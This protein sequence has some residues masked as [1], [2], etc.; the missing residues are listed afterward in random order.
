MIQFNYLPAF[1]LCLL[2]FTFAPSQK[3][4]ATHL[5]GG[6]LSYE[7]LGN[8]QYR[9]TLK[10]YR[11]CNGINAGSYEVMYMSA[12]CGSGAQYMTKVSSQEITPVCAGFTGTACNGGGGTYGIEEHIYQTTM[13]IPLTC[14]NIEL[15][16]RRCCRNGAITTLSSPLSERMYIETLLTDAAV[17]NNSPTFLNSPVSFICAGQPTDYNHGAS[18]P[19]GDDLQFSLTDCF[20]NDNDAVNYSAGFSATYPLSSAN[21]ITIDQET[22]ALSFTPST[23]GQVGVL[24]VLVEEFRNGVKISEISRDIQ[25]TVLTCT[26]DSPVMTGI[27]GSSNFSSTV[28]VGNTVSFFT[29]ASDPNAGD[30]VEMNWNQG[31]ASASF[32]VN[33]AGVYPVGTFNWTPTANN[34]GV[35]S[36]N[37]IVSDDNCPIIGLNT[38]TFDVTVILDDNL[39]NNSGSFTDPAIWSNNTVPT[40]DENIDISHDVNLSADF[41]VDVGSEFKIEPGATLTVEPGNTLT[42][43]GEFNNYGSIEGDVVIEG[44]NS[45]FVRLGECNNI[46]ITNSTNVLEADGCTIKGVLKLTDGTFSTNNQDVVMESDANGDAIVH[47]NGGTTLGDFIIRKYIQNTV[48]HHFL[49]SPVS[50]ASINELSDDIVINLNVAHPSLYYYDETIQSDHSSDGWKAPT[51]LSH[52]MT[53]G[54][55]VTAYFDATAGVTVDITGDFNAGT[56]CVPLNSTPP[57]IPYVGNCPP[58][59]WNLV[60]NPY[61]SPI[62]FDELMALSST[63]SDVENALYVWDPNTNTYLSYINGVSSPASFG[64]IIP[65]MQA[66][67]VRTSANT[68]LCFEDAVRVSDPN[69]ATND[70]YKSTTMNDPLLRLE[71]NGQ[72]LV[73]ETVFRFAEDATESYDNKFDARVLRDIQDAD[74]ELASQTSEG[75]LKINSLP[76]LASDPVVIPLLTEIKTAGSYQISIAQFDNFGTKDK[77][78]LEDHVLNIVHELNI[79]YSFASFVSGAASRFSVRVVPDAST[80]FEQVEKKAMRVFKCQ[81]DVLCIDM[82]T[83]NTSDQILNIF[84]ALGQNIH[85]INLEAGQ[86]VYQL[87]LPNL[88]QHDIYMVELSNASEVFKIAW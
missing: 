19:D 10:V 15:Y 68:N 38:Y 77:V 84:N 12:N 67:W 53:P 75:L 79:P 21:G 66:F 23:A 5:M 71:I 31:I 82:Q 86:Q 47:H 41:T 85:T 74:I 54:T 69:A 48:G 11:D 2:T 62:D 51:S 39:S 22:G 18:D 87:S 76:E 44:T 49:S 63:S 50:T 20:N 45:K 30:I 83:M 78:Y 43:N 88:K 46:E 36:F 29:N 81:A 64:G 25:F 56:V 65:S 61:P 72:G 27:D 17:C 1:I 16:W 28:L 40:S 80:S 73:D 8:N 52:L 42:V 34:V 14:T 3:I 37:V 35:N 13:N 32:S 4:H 9:V 24:C 33:N 26:N 70:F 59:G 58:D 60:G 57:V 7:C 55:G 6:D